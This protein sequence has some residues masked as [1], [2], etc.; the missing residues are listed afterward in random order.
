MRMQ[1]CLHPFRGDTNHFLAALRAGLLVLLLLTCNNFSS[2]L[3]AQTSVAL[4]NAEPH[5]GQPQ[6][7]F[8]QGNFQ[9]EEQNY[10]D[11]LQVFHQIEDL[12]YSAGSLFYNMGIS[13]TYLDSLGKANYY[14][15]KSRDFRE[16]RQQAERGIAFIESEKRN[17]G[18]Y[19]PYLPWYRFIDWFL[20]EI[21]RGFWIFWSLFLINAG[22]LILLGGWL[23]R[24]NR[25]LAFGGGV[26]ASAGLILLIAILLIHIIAQRYSQAV[27]IESM[28]PIYHSEQ[29]IQE[30]TSGIA[31][32]QSDI[33]RDRSSVM[34]SIN[35]ELTYAAANPAPVETYLANDNG[36]AD[37]AYEAYT[38]TLHAKRS[39][40]ISD[41]VYI[42]LR[43][44]ISGWVPENTVRIL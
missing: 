15:H 27:I 34:S 10:Q 31:T 21:N 24:R 43:N 26:T 18:T 32:Y 39:N 30:R 35:T 42:R 20:F 36:S 25:L 9:M 12:G 44:G 4:Q 40:N 23:I 1:I 38:V 6:A 11:A 22:V 17:R 2:G 5:T 8:N 19:I 37:F 16:S 33:S 28:V 3:M 7:L 14:F 41:W 29:A 13:Y